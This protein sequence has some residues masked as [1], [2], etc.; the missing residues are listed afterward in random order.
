MPTDGYHKEGALFVPDWTET[1]AG[2][3]VP[4]DLASEIEAETDGAYSFFHPETFRFAPQPPAREFY[5]HEVYGIAPAP[6]FGKPGLYL[7]PDPEPTD[8]D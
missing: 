2:L 7:V 6:P 8:D 5:I 3:F 4:W 1:R